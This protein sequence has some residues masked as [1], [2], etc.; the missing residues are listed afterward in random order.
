MSAPTFYIP[1]LER[2][3]SAVSRDERRSPTSSFGSSKG[4]RPT[5]ASLDLGRFSFSSAPETL[6]APPPYLREYDE[7]SRVPG[8]GEEQEVH[9][10]ARSL[11]K[12]GFMFPPFWLLGALILIIPLTPDPSWYSTKSAEQ[13]E[14][15]LQAMR[16]AE[17]RWA[18]RCAIA[19][20]ILLLLIFIVVGSLVLAHHYGRI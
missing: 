14:A 17:R 13:V 11:F 9:T 20:G 12:Y 7:E 16:V 3:C 19:F 2:P 10:M 18:W 8:Y 6:V 5:P 4:L 15:I 1:Q